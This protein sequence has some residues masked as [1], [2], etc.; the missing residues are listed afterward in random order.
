MDNLED[1]NSFMSIFMIII[2]I[3]ALYSAITG[4]GPA[5]NND[6]PKS[7]KEEANA[8]L[9]KFMW[10]IGPVITV[11][12]ILEYIG[13]EWAGWATYIVIIPAIVIYVIIFRKKFKDQL[14]K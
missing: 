8:L 4:K 9:R 13:Y 10:I 5:Y 7:M 12:G 6:Y 14:K 3:F 2:G 1:M 11:L